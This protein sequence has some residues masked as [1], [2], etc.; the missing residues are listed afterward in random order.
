MEEQFFDT[1]HGRIAFYDNRADGLAIV[2]LHANSIC[3]ESFA[4]QIAAFGN[5]Y[6]TIAI[7][8]PGH[9][10]SSDATDP[11]RSYSMSGY[12]SAVSEL[13]V[14][15]G[16]TRYMLLGHSLGGHVALELL[17]RHEASIAGAALFG[18][19]PIENS[20]EGLIAGFVPSPDMAYTGSL[21]I[22]E[23]QVGMIARMALGEK[24]EGNETFLAA[25]RRTDGRARQYMMEDAQAGKTSDQ[26]KVAETTAIPLLIINGADDPVVNLDYVDSLSYRNVWTGKPIRLAGTGHAVHREEAQAFNRLLAEFL[27]T[28]T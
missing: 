17:A 4:P 1:S 20:I 19:P 14:G 16:V 7:D 2:M 13:L 9:G 28:I 5:T 12:A 15:I 18:T 24:D 27:E 6:R 23:E 21:V 8:L 11:R 25:I 3:K 10:G 22:T 26:R